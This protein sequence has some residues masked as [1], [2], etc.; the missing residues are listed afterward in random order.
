VRALARYSLEGEILDLDKPQHL[1]DRELKPS[2]VVTRRRDVTQ[3]WA[4][5]VFRE[6]R[7]A[8]VRWWGFHNPDW[9]SYGIWS[10]GDASVVSVERLTTDHAAVV[11]A[12]QALNRSWGTGRSSD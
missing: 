1:L 12:A 6:R 2:R 7:W 9:G 3:A 10:S 5:S 8:G 4:L 11:R